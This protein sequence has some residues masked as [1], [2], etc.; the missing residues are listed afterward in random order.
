MKNTLKLDHEKQQIIMDRTFAKKSENTRSDEYRHLQEVRRD[1]P[2]YTVVRRQIRQKPNQEHYKGLT[3]DYMRAYI[4]THTGE[5]IDDSGQRTE[6]VE[7]A[8]TAFDELIL[9]SKC[10][11]S[12]YRYPVIKKWFLEQYPDVKNYTQQQN[13]ECDQQ[14][15]EISA[16]L[17]KEASAA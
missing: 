9:L 16:W 8:L 12:A 5:T 4:A 1:Y 13:R 15:I 3:Y 7:A 6:T 14:E 10:H 17:N 2:L 11:S